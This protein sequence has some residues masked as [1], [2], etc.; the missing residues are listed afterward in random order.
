MKISLFKASK[1]RW[2]G[3]TFG[4]ST[5]ALLGGCTA[6]EALQ[7]L[8]LI[9]LMMLPG[10]SSSSDDPLE[11]QSLLFQVC[12]VNA[13][14]PG[15]I[16]RLL[17]IF[18]NTQTACVTELQDLFVQF[19]S[20]AADIYDALIKLNACNAPLAPL[21][22]KLNHVLDTFNNAANGCVSEFNALE[23]TIQSQINRLSVL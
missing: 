18:E 6:N 14:Q 7:A 17:T 12:E 10:F 21:D 16:K 2:L 3:V 19:H 15:S 1:F 20:E 23:Q 9:L 8:L 11:S 13:T 22:I 5:V 4:L